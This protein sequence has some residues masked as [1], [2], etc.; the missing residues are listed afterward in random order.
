MRQYFIHDGLKEEGP[1]NLEEIKQK[2]LKKE[3]QIWYEGLEAW[4]NAN[5]IDE[6]KQIGRASCRER[7]LMPV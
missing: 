2:N 4:V 5:S 7:V 6:L 3:T 1:F